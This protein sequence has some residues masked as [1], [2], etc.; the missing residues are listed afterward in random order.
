M[1]HRLT[2]RGR[3][4]QMPMNE[5]TSK[6]MASLAGRVLRDPKATARE[7]K[8]AGCVLTQAADRRAVLAAMGRK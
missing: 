5:K 8:L 3:E 7:R 6:A 1:L 2:L 4:Q